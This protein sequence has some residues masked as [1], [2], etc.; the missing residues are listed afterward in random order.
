[1]IVT[2]FCALKDSGHATSVL[3]DDFRLADGY[4]MLTHFLLRKR[5]L[6]EGDDAPLRNLLLMFG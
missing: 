2:L 5:T 4:D 1:M 6:K 3:L